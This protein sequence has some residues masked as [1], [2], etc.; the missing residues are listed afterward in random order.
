[1][2]HDYGVRANVGIRGVWIFEVPEAE[3][4]STNSEKLESESASF[5]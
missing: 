5:Q 1:M 4:V 3:S 2:L